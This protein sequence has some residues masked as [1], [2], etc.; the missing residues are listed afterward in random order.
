MISI[1]STSNDMPPERLK[2]LLG[3]SSLFV[4]GGISAMQCEAVSG[5]FGKSHQLF[6]LHVQY[7]GGGRQDRPKRL[8]FKLGKSSKEFFF[9]DTIACRMSSPPLVQCYFAAYDPGS[10]QTCLLLE[11]LSGTHY[12]TEWPLP[13]SAQLCSQT[14]QEL[15]K[16]HA[17]WW[18]EARLEIDFRPVIPP[19]RAWIERR[20]L[21]REKLPEFMDFLGDRL[22]PAR[23]Q[24]YEDLLASPAQQWEKGKNA[25]QQTLLHGDMH[26]WNVFYPLD[27]KGSLYFFDWNMWDA[28][29]PT[30]DLAYMMAVHWYP[31]RRQWLEGE[32]LKVYHQKLVECGV[33]N[34]AWEELQ[35]DYRESVI[36]SLLIPVWQW[37]R[38]I[39]AGVWWSHLE[40]ICLAFED[41]KCGDLI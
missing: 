27:P 13:P 10:D 1:L 18:Q 7:A 8:F 39:E 6:R 40:R 30:D 37:V 32:L 11:D 16:I 14:V 41:L 21:A 20:A 15:A 28:G 26:V 25:P 4:E 24:V 9:Y 35:N 12:Q 22:A 36:R 33:T 38:G 23:R 29:C 5:L 34:Y 17:Q 3:E 2:S 19:G 31:E